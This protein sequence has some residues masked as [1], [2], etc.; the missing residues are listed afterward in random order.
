[1]C[2]RGVLDQRFESR[3]LRGI[4]EENNAPSLERDLLCGTPVQRLAL[5]EPSRLQSRGIGPGHAGEQPDFLGI[6]NLQ[7][8]R[9]Q[10]ARYDTRS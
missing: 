4:P 10:C 1:M 5:E 9:V 8:Q 2:A 3:R 6:W 7:R